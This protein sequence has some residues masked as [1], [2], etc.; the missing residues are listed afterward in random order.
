MSLAS[1]LSTPAA[2]GRLGVET[3]PYE[4]AIGYGDQALAIW[5]KL[6]LEQEEANS[7]LVAGRAQQELSRFT[8][9]IAAYKRALAIFQ[10]SHLERGQA[11]AYLQI[12]GLLLSRS[13][14]NKPLSYYTDSLVIAR[15]LDLPGY[16]AVTP[17]DVNLLAERLARDA[18]TYFEQAFH[19]YRELGLQRGEA[20]ALLGLGR[21]ALNMRQFPSAQEYYREA[22]EIDHRLGLARDESSALHGLGNLAS[23]MGRPQEAVTWYE[24]SL[25]IRRAH[26][27]ERDQ[28]V[29]LWA[30]A[31]AEGDL[32]HYERSDDRYQQS[33]AIWQRLGL[34]RDDALTVQRLGMLSERRGRYEEASEYAKTSLAAWRGLG[35][36]EYVAGVITGTGVLYDD[37][38]QYD[39]ALGN[40]RQALRLW[41]DLGMRKE[42]AITLG[43]LGETAYHL[44]QYSRAEAYL[45]Q[46]VA[47]FRSIKHPDAETEE[48]G[49]YMLMDLGRV[50]SDTGQY[51]RARGRFQQALTVFSRRGEEGLAHLVVCAMADTYLDEARLPEARPLLTQANDALR[52]GRYHLLAGEPA[53]AAERFQTRESGIEASRLTYQAAM[54]TGL[55]LAEE[56][57]QQWEQAGSSYTEATKLIEQSRQTVPTAERASFFSARDYGFPR[58]EPYEGLVRIHHQMGRDDEAYYWSEHTKARMLVELLGRAPSGASMGL[59]GDLRQQEDRLSREIAALGRQLEEDSGQPELRRQIDLLQ[60]DQAQLI[61][62][63]RQERPEYASMQYP[64][65]LRPSE[66]AL[67]PGEALLVYEVTEPRSFLF[68]IRQS[69]VERVFDI[70]LSRPE[71]ALMALAY[72]DAVAGAPSESDETASALARALGEKLYQFLLQ[73]ALAE[74]R[75]GEHVAIVPDEIVGLLPLEALISERRGKE[76][77]YVGEAW[78]FSY[79]Q[80]ATAMTIVRRLQKPGRGERV[81]VV[82]DPVFGT[83]DTRVRGQGGSPE[84]EDTLEAR[85]EVRES[86]REAYGDGVF[87]P[88]PEAGKIVGRLRPVYGD[89]LRPLVG[90][91][92]RER[93]LEREPLED[94]GALVFATHGVLDDDVPWLRQ[95]ALVLSLVDTDEGEDGYLTMTEV[96][97]LTL[98]AQVAALMACHT[99]AGKIVSGEGV[100]AMGRAF[101]YA[102]ARS[103]LATRWEAEDASANLLTEVFFRELA[104]GSDGATALHLARQQLRHDKRYAAPF[105][106]AGFVLI[107]ER[108]MAGRSG[109]APSGPRGDRVA[110][111]TGP[112]PHP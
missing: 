44:G 48:A 9:A 33:R 110:P 101:Q 19:T 47:V 91:E 99:G 36:R 28:A 24:Q 39:K 80:S 29:T 4:Q 25:A 95:P 93:T 90:K 46:S 106:W 16:V 81:L 77:Q 73:P 53:K 18:A 107:G 68:L 59:P 100:M 37:L 50:L 70:P 71:L 79:W 49:A 5:R 82:A 66:L 1:G 84:A 21:A 22:L 43:N 8:E 12:G 60:A 27:L 108:M 34:V 58:L 72:R 74:V 31:G 85:S 7:L 87:R 86:L 15:Q 112:R 61:A 26:G 89:R 35:V 75:P 88:L 30:L 14:L 23:E 2:T 40:Y 55:G 102:G 96:M 42:E 69:R 38:G 111:R 78:T 51:A 65:P 83:S 13:E 109:T 76:A 104:R 94:Y 64:E 105:Y 56:A 17:E 98:S 45:Q 103:V 11:E 92:A 54:R 10:G 63:I 41:R 52:W 32:A 62:R 3:A 6:G 67:D 57:L 20:L 97:Q